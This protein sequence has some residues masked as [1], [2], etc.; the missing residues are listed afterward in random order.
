MNLRRFICAP[1]LMPLILCAFGCQQTGSGFGKMRDSTQQFI[2]YFTG[3]TPLVAAKKMMNQ[4]SADE[5]RIGIND[6]VARKFAQKPPY[7]NEYEHIAKTD[8]DWLVRATAIR[9]LNLSRDASATPIFITALND[10]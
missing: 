8:S 2:D 1:L 6:L 3:H 4:Q 9:A 5:R 10:N 7:T